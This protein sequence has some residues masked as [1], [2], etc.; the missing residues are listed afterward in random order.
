MPKLVRKTPGTISKT[1]LPS[2]ASKRP[3]ENYSIP[4][5][6]TAAKSAFIAKVDKVLTQI[7][8]IETTP[9]NQEDYL[10]KGSRA[11]PIAKYEIKK[12]QPVLN[13]GTAIRK[14]R[15]AAIISP[16]YSRIYKKQ[17]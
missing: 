11:F 9:Y 12:V 7:K 10:T 17:I 1:S 6:P 16:G 15:E 4:V 3:L 8:G 5:G 2:F 14:G 13:L